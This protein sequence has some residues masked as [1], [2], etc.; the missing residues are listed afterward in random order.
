MNEHNYQID[1]TEGHDEIL[2]VPAN[3]YEEALHIQLSAGASS[4]NAGKMTSQKKP[5]SLQVNRQHLV[6]TYCS[7]LS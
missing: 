1:A 4:V 6:V 5:G 3:G 2:D 7:A